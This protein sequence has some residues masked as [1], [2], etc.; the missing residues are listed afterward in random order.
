MVRSVA[1]TNG[2]CVHGGSRDASRTMGPGAYTW[3]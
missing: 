1:L 2:V 3:R